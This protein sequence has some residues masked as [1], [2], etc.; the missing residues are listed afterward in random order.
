[1]VDADS[2]FQE[3]LT[4]EQE[5]RDDGCQAVCGVDESGRGPLAG[6]LVAAAV[7]APWPCSWKG[8]ND[9]KV[10]TSELRE[11]WYQ[12][13]MSQAMAVGVGLVSAWRIDRI[14]LQRANREAM[15]AAVT[16]LRAVPD[17]VVV[18]GPWR[19]PKL[20][21]PQTPLVGGDGRAISVAA[22]SVVAKV[23]RDR[24]MIRMDS[25]F[26]GYGFAR[27][28][29][30]STPEHLTALMT[31]GPCRIHRRSFQPVMMLLNR[32]KG[33]NLAGPPGTAAPGLKREI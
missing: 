24:M 5:L 3:M 25:E 19:I 32:Q 8:L 29:G 6:P 7:M 26:P 11:R 13:I 10:L 31:R 15:C 2:R 22:A 1:M 14:G 17:H 20:S 18:D 12:L 27:H 16:N 33:D 30:Y 9:S 4:V 21:I 28:K 23:T